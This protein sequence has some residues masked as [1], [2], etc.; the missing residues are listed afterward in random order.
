MTTATDETV[1]V[2]PSGLTLVC[3]WCVPRARLVELGRTY[4]VSHT[5]CT[6]CAEKFEQ[7]ASGVRP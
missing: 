2:E 4:R 1:R 3:A 5:M 7:G 6:A